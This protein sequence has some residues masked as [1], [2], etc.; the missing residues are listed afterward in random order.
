MAAYDDINGKRLA[1]VSV[2]SIVVTAVTVLAVQVIY[3][4][5]ADMVDSEK[6]RNSAYTRSNH[7]LEQQSQ[8]LTQYGVNPETGNITIPVDEMMKKMVAE[9]KNAHNEST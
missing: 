6:I 3:F 1:T 2:I 5:M 8:A 7:A 4:A 9:A